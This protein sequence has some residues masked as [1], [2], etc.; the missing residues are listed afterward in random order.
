MDDT[1]EGLWV[2]LP[3]STDGVYYWRVGAKASN[4]TI[5][6]SAAQSFTINLP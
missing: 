2:I 5:R 1:F 3:I 4:G 6:W